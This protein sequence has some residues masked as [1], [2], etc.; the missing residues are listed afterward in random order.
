MKGLRRSFQFV[1][2]NNP[3]MLQSADILGAD[4]II[5][6]LEDAVA[7]TEK[8]AARELLKSALLTFD[9]SKIER[10]V[11]VNPPDTEFGV[12][13]MEKLKGLPVDSYL[14]PK[15][16]VKTMKMAIELAKKTEFKGSLI[17]LLETAQG[18]EEAYEIIML[19]DS[20]DGVL[21]GGEDLT[22]DLGV[23]RTKEGN[24]I[25]YARTR[26]VSAGKAKAITII[27]TP[28]TDTEDLEGL[29]KDTQY[30]KSLG[31][32]SKA[33]ISPRHLDII[34]E[35]LSPTKKEILYALEV[36]DA[37]ELAKKE[38]RGVFS[39]KGKMVD[40][41]IMTRATNTIKTAEAIGLVKDGEYIG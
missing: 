1:P 17:P 25:N 35:V 29:K 4:S 22:A 30:A 19:D 11:R 7:L 26:V 14:I 32:N 8:D 23:V 16:T 38:G 41:P 37:S 13:D 40:A 31:F 9:Y 10:V 18:V 36:M 20:I 15:A 6:D 21:L 12:K 24:E 3:G 39:L 27:D 34:H 33:S 28:F 5:F 2:S